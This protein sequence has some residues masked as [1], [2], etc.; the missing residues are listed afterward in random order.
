MKNLTL[1]MSIEE[2]GAV[3]LGKDVFLF[4][5]YLSKELGY[6]FNMILTKCAFNEGMPSDYRGTKII[7]LDKKDNLRH[8]KE[9][10]KSYAKEI[11][12]LLLF[13]CQT[14]TSILAKIYKK[15]NKKGKIILKSDANKFV[16]NNKLIPLAL[17]KIKYNV[18]FRH[19]YKIRLFDMIVAETDDIYNL[20]Y[21]YGL[22]YT[23]I[24]KKLIKIYNGFDENEII[25]NEIKI[26]DFT[27]KEN[28]IITVGR[29]GSYQKNSE[30]FID[31]IKGMDLKDW[32]VKLIGPYT[33]DFY[34]YFSENSNSSAELPG[35]IENKKDLYNEYNNAKVFVL[36]SR[37]EGFALVL[38]EAARFGNFIVS[39]DIGG[40]KEVTNNGELGLILDSDINSF[41]EAIRKIV[42]G[43]IDLEK[44]YYEIV[45]NAKQK[46]MWEKIIKDEIINIKKLLKIV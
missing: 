1:I 11:D 42:N 4:P 40:I 29:M 18:F 2:I 10:L 44:K 34:N 5:Y 32:R 22:L 17:R 9:Y 31:A 36:T 8:Y 35:N 41:R 27:Q 20:F 19:K 39:T 16:V 26:K 7:R 46:F 37:W 45:K 15:F 21:K 43:E 24:R 23:N 28:V 25:R 13:H 33:D 30:L 6:S 14:E 12:V 38:P 3:H